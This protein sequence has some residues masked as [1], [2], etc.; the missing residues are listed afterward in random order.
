[1]SSVAKLVAEVELRGASEAS[2]WLSGFGSQL[3]ATGG[4]GHGFARGLGVATVAT[5]GFAAAAGGATVSA[6]SKMQDAF[7]PVGTLLGTHSA[8][9]AQLTGELKGFVASSPQDPNEIGMSAY[10]NLSAGISG[11][12]NVMKALE[13]ERKLA[14][15]GLGDIGQATDLVTSSMNSFSGEGLTADK[16]ARLLFGTI[17]SGKTTTSDL[18]QGFGQIAPLAAAAGIKFN[19]L[20]AGT[21][22]LTST[23][24]SASVAYSGLRGVISGVLKP[25]AEASKAAK[26]L[27]LDFTAAHLKNVG[28][29]AF[30]EEIKQKTGG[31][32]ETMAQLFGSVEGLNTVLALTGPQSKAFATNLTGIAAAGENLDA[33]AQETTETFSNRWATMKNRVTVTLSELGNKIFGWVTPIASKVSTGLSA[34]FAAFNGEGVTSDGFVGVMERIG[35]A[36]RGVVDWFRANWPQIQAVATAVFSAVAT[37][38][39]V[40]VQGLG[41]A[42]GWVREHWPEI[43]ATFR[44]MWAQV[45]PVLTGLVSTIRSAFGAVQAIVQT[46]VRIITNLWARF[47]GQLLAH[48]RTAFSGI[49]QMVRGALNVLGGIF[50]LIKAILTGK[51][52]AAW[53]AIKRIVSG[54]WQYITGYV[55]TAVNAVSTVIGGAMAVISAVWSTAW[56]AAKT[57]VTTV[58]GPVVSVVSGIIDS[59]VGFFSGLPGRIGA[60]VTGIKDKATEIGKAILD[61]VLDGVKA[62]GGFV[63]GIAGALANGIID[64]WNWVAGKINDFVPNSIG[65]GPFSLDLPDNPIPT[66]DHVALA[67]GG[68]I[69]KPTFA[70]LGEVAQ[71]QPEIVTPE[72]L[73][74]SVFRS[75]LRSSPA[76]GGAANRDRE[77]ALLEQLLAE[78]RKRD[79]GDTF[80]MQVRDDRHVI[81]AVERRRRHRERMARAS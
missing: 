12:A 19:D 6:M 32:T 75:E 73:M 78:L 55:R 47:G 14:Q 63:A 41:V 56:N 43:S 9:Y 26:Q 4:R 48:V 66:F 28:L 20:L 44:S 35:V 60:F 31:N 67:K 49:A 15:A 72:T 59:I 30:L 42:V 2:R 74:R 51:W 36:A 23:G 80:V 34:M 46:A 68:V 29:P 25:T 38:V 54:A 7:S 65:W 11:T 10:T 53:D 64:A 57:L 76:P 5:A 8:A 37:G 58:F 77:V 18:A 61:G 22:A 27:G 71:A 1:M 21:A 13:A 81:E 3:D 69:T 70:L 16:A 24:Q 40:L 79:T 45:R 50:D 39:G 52:G 62:A 33:R 17:A